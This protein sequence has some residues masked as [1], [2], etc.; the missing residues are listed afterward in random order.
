VETVAPLV[1]ADGKRLARASASS[2][3]PF[4]GAPHPRVALLLGTDS[5]QR[6][7][8]ARRV[9]RMA[10]DVRDFAE[11]A[12]GSALALTECELREEVAAALSQGLRSSRVL[13]SVDPEE[14][15]SRLAAA[16]A[17]VV[18]GDDARPLAEAAAAGKP[19]YVYPGPEPRPSRGR[20]ARRFVERRAHERPANRRGTPRPQQGLEYLCA[21][22]LERGIVQPA[23]DLQALHRALYDRGIALAF[24]APLDTR[25]RPALREAPEVARRVEQLLGHPSGSGSASRSVP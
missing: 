21:R 12:G 14:L 19:V 2:E 10:D 11:R 3:D 22:L 17:V 8:D 20:G 4:A 1:R 23:Q 7:L 18:P 6:R 5:A 13:R 25:A 16:D 9:R 24:G 15:A